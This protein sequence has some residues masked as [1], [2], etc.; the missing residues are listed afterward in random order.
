MVA[1]AYTAAPLGF[2]G[3]VVHVEADLTNGLPSL[4]IVGLGS[5]AVDEARDRVRSAIVNSLLDFPKK[6]ITINLAPAELPKDGGHYDLAIAVAILLASN[7][8]TT[9]DIP[10]SLFFAAELGLDGAIRPVRSI[11]SIAEAAQVHGATTLF[12]APENAPQASLVPGLSIIPVSSLK[13]L[14]LHL[15]NEQQIQP[16]RAKTVLEDMPEEAQNYLDDVHGQAQAKRALIIAAAGHH[17]LLISGSP[18]TGKS[19]LSKVLVD[20]LPPLQRT[21][22]LAITKL[23]SLAGE[24]ID[25][26]VARRPYRTPH[27]TASRISL[28]GGGAKPKPGE[29]SL[30]HLGVLMLDEMPE[31]PRATLEALR[32][33]LEDRSVSISRVEGH[34]HYPANFMLVGTMNPCP[35]G[36]Y[37]DAT[38]ECSCTS[39]QIIAYQKRLSGPL[40]DRI[41]LRVHA[42]KVPHQAILQAAQDT[43]TEHDQAK[44]LIAHVRDAQTARFGSALKTNAT[45]NNRDIKRFATPSPA[46]QQLLDRAATRLDL[47][48]R[49]YLRIIRIART[50][51]D[52]ADH[53]TIEADDIAEALQYRG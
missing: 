14:F 8:L 4:Q 24:T 40:L 26:I 46:A 30:A 49:S 53:A 47:N 13:A 20:L 28:I 33:P 7:Q 29:V 19:M 38:R 3:R 36:Y 1:V 45:M 18:G 43:H 31:Y 32:Q 27:H 44:S 11:V 42:A 15:K 25:S 35:C 21:E 41:D 16:Y 10:T 51:A 9:H 17:N 48:P 52:M 37:G 39:T 50:I 6:K 2:D 22:Q 34:V 5:K 23:H 12:I